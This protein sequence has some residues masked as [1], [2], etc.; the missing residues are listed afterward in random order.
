MPLLNLYRSIVLD[1]DGQDIDLEGRSLVRLPLYRQHLVL[2]KRK[3]H[4]TP[5]RDSARDAFS[6]WATFADIGAD[7]T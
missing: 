4:A 7:S 1:L 6:A 2:W 5:L 3:P